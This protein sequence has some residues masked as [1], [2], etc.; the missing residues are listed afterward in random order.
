MLLKN[1]DL[2]NGL[3]N[4]SRGVVTGFNEDN[5]PKVTFQT[6]AGSIRRKHI[7]PDAF[8]TEQV[9]LVMFV[10]VVFVLTCEGLHT[11]LGTN[12]G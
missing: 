8:S 9:M 5:H 10:A 3:V 7:L 2:S 4:G 12:K 11:E 1:L 6:A